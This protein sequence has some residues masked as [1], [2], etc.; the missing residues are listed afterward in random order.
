M[1]AKI[2]ASRAAN[3]LPALSS[4]STLVAHA[5]SH[6]KAMADSDSIYHTSNA[7]LKSLVSGWQRVG[8]NVGRGPNVDILHSAFMQSSGHRANIMGD[9]THAGVGTF[10]TD[11]GM[12]YVTVVFVKLGGSEPTTTTTTA[13]PTTT[14]AAPPPTTA[15]P[16]PTTTTPAPAPVKASTSKT[17]TTTSTAPT[18][19]TTT[20]PEPEP[21]PPTWEQVRRHLPEM[22]IPDMRPCVR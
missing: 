9:F 14:T 6:S 3:G 2:N 8:E 20:A 13:P 21:E 12:M 17:S 4:H 10:V 11:E 18:T 22:G 7:T 19:T 1:L 5:R 15:A 16:A